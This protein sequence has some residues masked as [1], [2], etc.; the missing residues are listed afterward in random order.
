MGDEKDRLGEKLAA[1]SMAAINQ[2]AARRDRALLAKL[3]REVEERVAKNRKERRKPRAFNQILCP[4]DFGPSSLKALAL[5]KQIASENDAALCVIHVCPAILIPLGGTAT[6]AAAEQAARDRLQEVATKRLAGVPHELLVT[7]G[8]AA[9]R[10]TKVQS[11]LGVD[12][13]V[14]GTH[15]RRGVP[16]F[17]LGSV[18]ESVV[19][20]AACPV[21][22]MRAK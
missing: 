16:R 5:A 6:A 2:W 4:I 3:Q 14:M 20:K 8:D 22:T 1:A 7:T 15:G 13:I 12:L 11:T 21:L 9:E 17:F 18:A 19:R 10:V